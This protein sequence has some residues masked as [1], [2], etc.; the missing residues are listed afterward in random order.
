MPIDTINSRQP[1][2]ASV[3]RRGPSTSK[4]QQIGLETLNNLIIIVFEHQRLT[5]KD[6]SQ[7]GD[8]SWLLA[9]EFEV[10]SLKR[11]RG[12]WQ[13]KV[14]HYIGIIMLPSGMTLEIL[15]KPIAT[16]HNA[17]TNGT[18]TYDIAL[19]RQWVQQMLS[20]LFDKDNNRLPHRKNLAQI[21]TNLQPLPSLPMQPLPLSEWLVKQFLQLLPRYRP[22]HHYQASVQNKS[23]LQGKLLIKE[24]LRRNATQP[25]KFVSEVS[26]LSI[27]M[28]SNRLIK[29]ALVLLEPLVVRSS[30]SE[31]SNGSIRILPAQPLLFWQA[32]TAC[33]QYELRQLDSLYL[34]AKRQLA[35][36]PLAREQ[37]QS[38]QQLLEWAYWLLQRQQLA[39]QVGNSLRANNSAL[40]AARQPRLCILFNMNQAFEQWAS[41]RIAM[42]FEQLDTNYQTLYQSQHSWL[43]DKWGQ[44]CLSMRPDLLIGKRFTSTS[45]SRDVDGVD[46][47][48][49]NTHLNTNNNADNAVDQN[50]HH[51]LNGAQ[52]S[53]NCS[54]VIDIK[55]K[56][57]AQP[58]AI[59]ASDAYQLTSYAQAYQAEQVWLVYPVANASINNIHRPT[60]LKQHSATEHSD[61][62]QQAELWL[63]PFNVLT[64]TLNDC[65]LVTK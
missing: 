48:C 55:W 38:A 17:S 11:Q 32:V 6:F 9:Q 61:R 14:G 37:L 28:L 7:A 35:M 21:S 15:P 49:N 40:A 51:Q 58:S 42:S 64:A 45:D 29:S 19:T 25:H 12:Q 65:P 43:R 53:F 4:H 33:N 54:H 3:N 31:H 60:V 26:S 46:G 1:Q 27:D 16:D 62:S 50:H 59:S 63:M 41:L 57:L 56:A 23:M 10:F 47:F 22:A 52:D 39:V 13:L 2:L 44:N 8:F 34:S 5:A 24:Q 20:D 30:C 36:Q 18:S